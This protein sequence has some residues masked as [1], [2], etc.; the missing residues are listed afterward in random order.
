MLLCL[1]GAYEV[2]S[3]AVGRGT[4]TLLRR[5]VWGWLA[6]RDQAVPHTFP[7]CQHGGVAFRATWSQYA[8]SLLLPTQ[9]TAAASFFNPAQ[10]RPDFLVQIT[11]ALFTFHT[12]KGKTPW[13]LLEQMP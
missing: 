6:G 5:Y 7:G 11:I 4:S 13:L 3:P 2:A 9:E 1:P 12:P 10:V 8:F